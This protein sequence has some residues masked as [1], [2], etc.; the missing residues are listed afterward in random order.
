MSMKVRIEIKGKVS[1]EE[2]VQLRR[3]VGWDTKGDYNK[4]LAESFF[5]LSARDG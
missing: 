2:I 3:S 5:Y 1:H 4:I